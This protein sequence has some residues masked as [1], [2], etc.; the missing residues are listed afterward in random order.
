MVFV[1]IT[2][3]ERFE[4]D[5]MAAQRPAIPPPIISTSVSK[6]VMIIAPYTKNLPGS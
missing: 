4:A 6:I 2:V 5:E 1:A 3:F